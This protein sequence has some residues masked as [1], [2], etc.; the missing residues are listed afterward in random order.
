MSAPVIPLGFKLQP[1][2][3]YPDALT[4]KEIGE[5]AKLTLE[6]RRRLGPKNLVNFSVA[7]LTF[8]DINK[9][10]H[11]TPLKAF[12]GNSIGH[13]PP[14]GGHAERLALAQAINEAIQQGWNPSIFIKQTLNV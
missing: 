5:F 12:K 3:A 8:I 14:R 1:A 13:K 11:S 4:H 6:E 10:R 9:K 7:Q 2:I